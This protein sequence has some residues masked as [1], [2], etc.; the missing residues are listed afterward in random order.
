MKNSLLSLLILTL[1]FSVTS[2][3]IINEYS[4]SNMTGVTDAY[5]EREDWVELHN[6]TATAVDLTGYFLS[7]KSTN[8]F[9]W[10]IPSG[11]IPANGFK[12]V[13]CS[14]RNTVNGTQ[15]HPNFNLKQTK[16]DWIILTNVAGVVEDSL[17]LVHMTK[18]D[19]SV[20]RSTNGATDW[21]LFTTP[22]PNAN[23]TGA[24]NFYV[25]KPVISLAPP[26][27]ARIL[28]KMLS[29]RV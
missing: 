4:C 7:N 8:L 6:P 12:M 27:K 13:F 24:Q 10:V 17:K 16:G 2:Q 5:G 15:L 18:A 1:T 21:K 9:K 19:H 20:G 29:L 22:T 14:N 23:N 28:L 26:G 25:P 3:V 11:T